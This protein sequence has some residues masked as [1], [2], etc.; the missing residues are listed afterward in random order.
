MALADLRVL[1]QQRHKDRV[2]Y[3]GELDHVRATATAAVPARA[4]VLDPKTGLPLLAKA[5]GQPVVAPAQDR[6]GA[7]LESLA[8]YAPPSPRRRW[9]TPPSRPT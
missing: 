7:P 9:R 8:A 5:T 1:E 4:P 2:F 6:K 3:S